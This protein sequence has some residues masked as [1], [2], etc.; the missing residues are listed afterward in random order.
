MHGQHLEA[1]GYHPLADS[2][3]EA[4]IAKYLADVRDL[5]SRCADVMPDHAAYIAQHCAAG[6]AQRTA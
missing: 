5:V 4:Q 2:L 3:D 1:A 6:P